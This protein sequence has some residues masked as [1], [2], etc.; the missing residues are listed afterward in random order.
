MNK[1]IRLGSVLCGGIFLFVGGI[2]GAV[3]LIVSSVMKSIVTDFETELEEFRTYAVIGEGEIVDA[4][5]GGTEIRYEDT[6]GN[7]FFKSFNI[8]SSDLG[9]GT[10]LTVYYDPENPA[11]CMVPDLESGV[12]ASIY[13]IFNVVG[14]IVL[15]LF[16]GIGIVVMIMGFIA[17]KSIKEP[18]KK[19]ENLQMAE[20]N[21]YTSGN[22]WGDEFDKQN[23]DAFGNQTADP[24][25]GAYT[26]S[27][28]SNTQHAGNYSGI[29]KNL[30]D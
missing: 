7:V 21:A 11:E 17:S 24:F 23:N 14:W 26:D 12:L 15:I 20:N 9:V 29:N 10:Y 6:E 27:Y 2:V 8:Y 30:L 25:T 3:F 28:D 5:D 1:G 18:P 13:K 22:T 4:Y 19:S 16:G